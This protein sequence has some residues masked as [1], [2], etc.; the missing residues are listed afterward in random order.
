MNS[1]R[2]LI[3]RNMITEHLIISAID[4][5]SYLCLPVKILKLLM[6]RI[7]EMHF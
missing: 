3:S 4:S 1:N 5:L 7:I 6:P 2:V